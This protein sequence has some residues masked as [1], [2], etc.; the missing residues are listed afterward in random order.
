VVLPSNGIGPP[1]GPGASAPTMT[2]VVATFG[3][4]ARAYFLADYTILVWSTNILA[5]LR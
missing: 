4:P 2:E 5:N 1:P 3:Q